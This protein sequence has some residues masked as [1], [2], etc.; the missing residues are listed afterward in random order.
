[1]VLL[2][3]SLWKRGCRG[4]HFFLNA[5]VFGAAT[6]IDYPTPG[7]L[8]ESWNPIR[9]FPIVS[10]RNGQ[11]QKREIDVVIESPRMAPPRPL[12]A[13]SD[14][15]APREIVVCSMEP[16][17]DVRRRIQLL[18]SELLKL[19][20]SLK[21]L[22]VE[23]PLDVAHA[24]LNRRWVHGNPVG[25]VRHEGDVKVLRPLKL[26]PRVL[27]AASDHSLETQVMR[28]ARVASMH[29]PTLWINDANYAGL[30]ARTQWP[31]LYDVTDDW[32]LA[33]MTDRERHRLAQ[34]DRSLLE[35]ARVVVVCSPDLAKSRGRRREVELIPNGVDV[36]LFRDPQPRPSDLPSGPV[37]LYPGVL[38]E[39]RLDLELCVDL[40]MSRNDICLVFVGPDAL[41]SS[42]SARLRNLANVHVLGARPYT[43]VPSYLQHADVLVVPHVRS[44]FTESLDPIKA[45]EC[46]AVGRPT[47]A[48]PV[49]GF[50]D[51]GPPVHVVDREHFVGV[52]GEIIDGGWRPALSLDV[53]SWADRAT[54]FD[55][56]LRI[57]R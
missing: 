22:Y 54:I 19:D 1:M 20:P 57:C 30:V 10:R 27:G 33:S 17:G 14:D 36:E 12:L 52:V 47:V 15:R 31:A 45:Y 53:A 42:T 56:A 4:E 50:R 24:A 25:R 7:A 46:L 21:V 40:A 18:L 9:L 29:K 35:I 34:R 16:W 38:H 55:A 3:S 13:D 11:S 43:S 28:A 37:A 32:L 23:P 6:G 26:L 49:A 48:T 51:L 2:A 39:D 5:T 8:H 44:P 41:R